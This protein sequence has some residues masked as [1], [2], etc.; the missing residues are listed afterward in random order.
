MKATISLPDGETISRDNEE[1]LG[2]GLQLGEEHSF[3]AA[4]DADARFVLVIALK[5]PNDDTSHT[6]WR[7]SLPELSDLL[8][9][10]GGEARQEKWG[11]F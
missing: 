9:S 7:G 1:G 10:N 4:I 5:G 6:A 11:S 2:V 8:L 3:A